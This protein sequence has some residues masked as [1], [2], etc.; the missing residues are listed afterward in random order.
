L[1]LVIHSLVELGTTDLTQHLGVNL[2]SV[3]VCCFLVAFLVVFLA[4]RLK[5]LAIVRDEGEGG[6]TSTDNTTRCDC[7]GEVWSRRKYMETP[8]SSIALII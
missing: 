2:C 4:F 8:P 7:S 1:I 5:L 3:A 6:R